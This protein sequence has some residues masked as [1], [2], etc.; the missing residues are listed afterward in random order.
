[1]HRDGPAWLLTGAA[2]GQRATAPEHAWVAVS[3]PVRS[4]TDLGG[5]MRQIAFLCGI[6]QGG[7][8]DGG[9]ARFDDV[10]RLGVMRLLYELW[11][12]PLLDEFVETMIGGLIREDRRGLLR[13]TLRRYLAFGGTQRPTAESLGIH[14]NTL[15]YRLRQIR[16]QLDVDPDD[17][18]ARLNLHVALVASE[19]PPATS[20]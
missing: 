2:T 13:Q 18:E 11:G 6:R 8:I 19:L 1:M 9:I 4:P 20:S 16:A 12:T 15:T 3:G 17:P 14:R 5:A 7:A 10:S